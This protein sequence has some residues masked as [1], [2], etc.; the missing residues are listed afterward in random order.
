MRVPRALAKVRVQV[1]AKTKAKA[2]ARNEHLKHVCVVARKDTGQLTAN[3][4][5]RH[6][7]TAERLVTCE[8][9]VETRTHTRLRRMQTNPVQKSL[10]KQFGAWLFETLLTMITVIAL[11]SM[12]EHSDESQFTGFP[13]HRD[14]S[15]FRKVIED[16]E[17]D[18]NSRKVVM[19]IEMDEQDS[20]GRQIKT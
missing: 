11:R 14:E 18:Q 1:Q 20:N 3:S 7:Q 12:P 13:E 5:L 9:C 15:K 16:V 17:T 8:P 2:I 19:K 10:S 4:R 6:V